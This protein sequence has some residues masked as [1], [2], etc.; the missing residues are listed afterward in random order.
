MGLRMT[1][2]DRRDQLLAIIQAK[3]R[4]A[5]TR[6][7]FKADAIAEE[8]G[9]SVVW[10][11]ELVGEEYIRLRDKLPGGPSR[12]GLVAGLRREIREL[13]RKLREL[14]EG[15]KT[16]L[17]QKLDEAIRHIELLDGENRMLRERVADLE[18]RLNEGKIVITRV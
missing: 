12:E 4:I 7:D 3:F 1:K 9:V 10:L 15:Y 8:A 17:R 18:K 16:S 2:E 13:R 14:K 11:Y 6:D 5:H